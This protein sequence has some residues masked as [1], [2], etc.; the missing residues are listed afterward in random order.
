MSAAT[1]TAPDAATLRRAAIEHAC[2]PPDTG[3]RATRSPLVAL[4]PD[5]V[6]PSDEMWALAEEVTGRT[7]EPCWAASASWVRAARLRAA[8]NRWAIRQVGVMATR[9]HVRAREMW[10]SATTTEERTR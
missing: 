5:D 1:L 10:R 4:I 9:D 3:L 6:H 2:I 8:L 7:I